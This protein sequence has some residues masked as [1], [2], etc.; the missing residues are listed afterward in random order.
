MADYQQA[1]EYAFA[2][3][4]TDSSEIQIHLND[5][6]LWKML[7]RNG[8]SQEELYAIFNGLYGLELWRILRGAQIFDQKT[9]GLLLLIASKGLL[10]DLI[11][12]LQYFLGL[13]QSTEMCS[14]TVQHLNS[15]PACKVQ[16]WLSASLA[17]Y[18]LVSDRRS[19]THEKFSSKGA[20]KGGIA[21][22]IGILTV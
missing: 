13:E 10:Q 15:M 12:E 9:A 20:V 1:F 17:Y 5:L 8:F 21:P 11:R 22:N 7:K 4:L 16:Q 19:L 3:D 2:L 6:P 18:E 14:S